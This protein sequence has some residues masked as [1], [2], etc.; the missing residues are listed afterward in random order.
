[1][2]H[3]RRRRRKHYNDCASKVRYGSQEEA[4]AEQPAQTAY[5]CKRC[6]CWHLS[7]ILLDKSVK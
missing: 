5:L 1:M 6:D 4:S 7:T 2:P 3:E